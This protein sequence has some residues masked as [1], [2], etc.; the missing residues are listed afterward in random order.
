MTDS[1][2]QHQSWLVRCWR[3]RHLLRI[4]FEALGC[5]W[6]D[7]KKKRDNW[8]VPLTLAQ[9]W[10][11]ALGMCDVR[12]NWVYSYEECKERRRRR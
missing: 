8:F 6:L 9:S 2:Y 1:R 7:R 3:D 12:R 5:W 11:M 4:P 10:H